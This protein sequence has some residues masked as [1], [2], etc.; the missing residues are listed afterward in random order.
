[1]SEAFEQELAQIREDIKNEEIRNNNPLAA[2]PHLAFEQELAAIRNRI[3]REDAQQAF[4]QTDDYSYPTKMGTALGIGAGDFGG[5][6]LFG[7]PAQLLGNIGKMKDTVDDRV[8]DLFRTLVKDND[9][10]VPDDVLPQAAPVDPGF[11]T[12]LS[13]LGMFI[14]LLIDQAYQTVRQIA[15]R[16]AEIGK[17]P[18][19]QIG[20]AARDHASPEI[21]C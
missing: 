13:A 1:M 6:I 11:A 4:Q 9:M 8:S 12:S 20:I 7:I 2:I 14:L 3:A 18:P 21:C 16:A 10:S 15:D 17:R 19:L 5:K